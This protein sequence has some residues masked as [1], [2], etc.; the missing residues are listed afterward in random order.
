MKKVLLALSFVALASCSKKERTRS[1]KNVAYTIETTVLENG[2]TF[3][4]YH[5]PLLNQ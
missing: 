1:F 4:V 2:K 3:R 5:N